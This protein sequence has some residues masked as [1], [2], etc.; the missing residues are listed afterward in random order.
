MILPRRN[1]D[2]TQVMPNRAINGI[3]H[4]LFNRTGF[5]LVDVIEV[6]NPS[7]VYF[8]YDIRVTGNRVR[9]SD[10]DLAISNDLQQAN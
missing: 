1:L 7:I 10:V 4:P 2:L 5:A 3:A 8:R 6:G 9:P